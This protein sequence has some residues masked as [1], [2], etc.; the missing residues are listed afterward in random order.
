MLIKAP[1]SNSIWHL[2]SLHPKPGPVS[3]CRAPG[4][5][6]PL[7]PET[8]CSF[9]R[10]GE[11]EGA[12]LSGRGGF[13]ACQPGGRGGG[14]DVDARGRTCVSHRQGAL[15]CPVWAGASPLLP[16]ACLGAVFHGPQHLRRVQL[17]PAHA[18]SHAVLPPLFSRW[19]KGL[20]AHCLAQV[21]S[22]FQENL[23]MITTPPFCLL[24]KF[25]RNSPFVLQELTECATWLTLTRDPRDPR[26]PNSSVP[27]GEGAKMQIP[28]PIPLKRSQSG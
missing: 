10:P 23:P 27:A 16:W 12:A 8:R 20:R 2:S 15:R 6:G 3:A 21:P 7:P 28:R 11:K 17:S 4:E 19:V 18:T 24:L 26:L 22:R 9:R 5:R 13:A 1:N 25:R 14:G